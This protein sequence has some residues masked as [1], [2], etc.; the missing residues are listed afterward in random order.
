MAIAEEVIVPPPD[1]EMSSDQWS[2]FVASWDCNSYNNL[3]EMQ[4]PRSVSVHTL[5]DIF[6]LAMGTGGIA[7]YLGG[8]YQR[9]EQEYDVARPDWTIAHA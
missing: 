5:A 3:S 8:F 6:A 9:S 2:E 1:Y 4:E 7:L